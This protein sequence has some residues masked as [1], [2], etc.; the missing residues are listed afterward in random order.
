MTPKDR[1]KQLERA[2]RDAIDTITYLAPERFDDEEHEQNF[3][4]SL[5]NLQ[6]IAKKSEKERYNAPRTKK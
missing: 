6:R 4:N 3:M 5:D 1:I 2:L